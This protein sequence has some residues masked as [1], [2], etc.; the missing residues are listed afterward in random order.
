MKNAEHNI[1]RTSPRSPIV[2][3]CLAMMGLLSASAAAAEPLG[4]NRDIRPILV[5]TCFSCHGPDSAARKADLR[6]DQ[7]DAAITM[8]A[9]KPGDP[10]ASEMMRRILSTDP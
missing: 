9:I 10:A 3:C 7:R 1:C 2:A 4:Y 8:S 6:L 5:D